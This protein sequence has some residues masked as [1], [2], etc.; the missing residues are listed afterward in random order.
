VEGTKG[1]F[2]MTVSWMLW[3]LCKL[4]EEV[5][6]ITPANEEFGYRIKE[7]DEKSQE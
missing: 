7:D 3:H 4:L 1:D 2:Q 6:S 5:E